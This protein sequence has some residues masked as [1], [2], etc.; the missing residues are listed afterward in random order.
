MALSETPSWL[1]SS[2]VT[3][4]P[5]NDLRG[6]RL[7]PNWRMNQKP[8][9]RTGKKSEGGTP[10]VQRACKNRD[11]TQI[12][13]RPVQRGKAFKDGKL[14]LFEP[15]VGI[16]VV[17]GWPRLRAWRKTPKGKQFKPCRPNLWLGPE[18]QVGHPRNR[19]CVPM[20]VR[21][22]TEERRPTGEV[23]VIAEAWRVYLALQEEVGRRG[24]P[25][26][27]ALECPGRVE[28]AD[29]S[30][31]ECLAANARKHAHDF[32]SSNAE[33]ALQPDR[34]KQ[35]LDFHAQMRSARLI[36][37]RTLDEF[38]G[39]FPR[40]VRSLVARFGSRQWHM[41]RLALT[42]EGRQMI[43]SNPGLAFCIASN[44]VFRENT[45]PGR[46]AKRLLR[47]RRREAC[48][49]L[50]WPETEATVR[51]LSRIPP[52]ACHVTLLLSLRRALQGEM[53]PRC[54]KMIRSQRVLGIDLLA[55][56]D[57]IP[58]RPRLTP[59]LLHELAQGT[60]EDG[61]AGAVGPWL[62]LF[63]DS[64]SMERLL[65]REGEPPPLLHSLAGLTRY[66][67]QL[68]QA[69]NDA[70]HVARMSD[71]GQLDLES[72]LPEPPLAGTDSILPLCTPKDIREEA[73]EMRHCVL[74]Y[75]D[76]VRQGR[77]YIYRILAPQRV[78]LE[79]RRRQGNW[80]LAQVFGRANTQATG[81][82]RGL[83]DTWLD[84]FQVPDDDLPFQH[85][86]LPDISHATS[87]S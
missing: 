63:R 85:L 1:A 39:T 26:L 11:M 21:P 58:L 69:Y 14:Y 35:F 5:R 41:A 86:A 23:P 17:A 44:W 28:P 37:H 57:C 4:P 2:S 25:P 24:L 22:F 42:H 80:R 38:A 8:L 29:P 67:N 78:T 43:E 60:D 20:D 10:F 87:A 81:E 32:L 76:A 18:P 31:E 55:A 56:I 77:S 84:G 3:L 83:I 36:H 71:L 59:A 61:M 66:H 30:R 64:C 33:G 6:L 54:L 40:E 73:E 72:P 7:K 74:S 12:D 15:K 75:L 48:R 68:T 65:E 47:I 34:L 9:R 50:A 45:H 19:D 52:E 16:L 51:L 27:P 46:T 49:W 79:I 70:I 62:G 82:I 53:S 13:S